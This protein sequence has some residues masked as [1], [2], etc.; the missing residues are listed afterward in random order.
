MVHKDPSFWIYIWPLDGTAD[1]VF[2]SFLSLFL[3]PVSLFSPR[4]PFPLTCS[5]LCYFFFYTVA[6]QNRSLQMWR[7]IWSLVRFFM[8]DYQ[9]WYTQAW[10]EEW[11]H[12]HSGLTYAWFSC[13]LM[14]VNFEFWS[15]RSVSQFG[16][17][18]GEIN[19]GKYYLCYLGFRLLNTSSSFKTP[20]ERRLLL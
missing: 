3:F 13:R 15:L 11:T 2:I 20:L 7:A 6:V 4:S 18:A 12:I 10:A 8:E 19:I 16:M 5:L 17:R 9:P 14:T 1:R